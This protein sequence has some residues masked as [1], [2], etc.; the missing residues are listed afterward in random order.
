M[1]RREAPAAGPG[2]RALIVDVVRS[3]VAISR[4]E[5]A[6]LTGLTQPSISNIVRDLIADGIIHEV[7]SADSV[8]GRRRKLIAISPANR[9]G[10]G[11]NLGPDT[12]TCVAIDLTGGVVGR[13]VV[14][15]LPDEIWRA[16]RLAERF[17]AFTDGLA[18]PRDRIE[19]LAIVMPA[20]GPGGADRPQPGGGHSQPGQAHPGQA[21][22]A[23]GLGLSQGA[24]LGLSQAAGL[25][26]SQAAAGLGDDSAEVRTEL[27]K[28]LG[29]SVLVENDAA[30]A[31]LGEFWSRRVSREQAFGCIYLSTGIGA[32]F[33]FG[34]ALYRGASFGAGELGHVSIDY[35]GRSCPCGNL[36]CVEQYA[37]MRAIVLAAREHP[38]LRSRLPLD[39]SESSAY[40]AVARAA[41]N[42]DQD[43][44]QVL[45]QAAERLSAAAT[46]M[47][48][49]LDLGR[50]VLTGPGV[51]RAGSI[52]A[53][54]LR[55]HLERTA[56]SRRRHGVT[57]ELS[58][59][60]R[61]AAGIGAAALV[62]QASVAPGHTPGQTA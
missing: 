49:L 6:E 16:D 61:D 17:D 40:D 1:A 43:A 8:L 3:S 12:V 20:P 44:Y 33:V 39:G 5:L 14:P 51:A 57:V 4:V 18:L 11:F 26:L 32:G 22:G 37:S 59:Q 13:E 45:D 46:S 54:R 34:G 30:A 28:R 38:G 21:P 25:G 52:F 53:R 29:V 42:G 24:G 60:P 27:E 58:A 35:A 36:G 47:V 9:F 55:G 10:V 31:A 23:A 2:S 19:G 48:N 50:L 7:G 15:R 62:V 56:H 41:V